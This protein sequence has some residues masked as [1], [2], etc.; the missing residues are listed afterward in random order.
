MG[1]ARIP[2]PLQ[3]FTGHREIA[4]IPAKVPEIAKAIAEGKKA[5][6]AKVWEGASAGLP[7]V[8]DQIQSRIDVLSKSKAK[9][10]TADAA[11]SGLEGVKKLWAEAQEFYKAGKASE[12]MDAMKAV[13]GK[14]SELLTSLGMPVPDALK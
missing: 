11:K 2:P 12:A 7:K 8:F 10:A 6:L 13:K 5:E 14:T 3:G 9:K 1:T 4:T